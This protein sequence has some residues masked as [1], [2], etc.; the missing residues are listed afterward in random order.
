[1]TRKEEKQIK[2]PNCGSPELWYE[3]D[4]IHFSN[5]IDKITV[6]DAWIALKC[7]K[8]WSEWDLR[9]D[10]WKV[11]NLFVPSKEVQDILNK[12][13]DSTPPSRKRG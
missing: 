3:A 9:A 5:Y 2:C 11:R 4:D 8:C 1:M 6:G 13:F 7:R 10:N 12:P